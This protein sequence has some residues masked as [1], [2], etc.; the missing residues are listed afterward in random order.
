[1]TDAKERWEYYGENDPYFAVS[2]F[3]KF[4][5]ANLN[6]AGRNE[7]FSSGTVHVQRIRTEIQEHFESDF[8]PKSAIDFGCGVGR[9]VIPLAGWAEEVMGVDISEKMLAEA[10]RNCEARAIDNVKFVQTDAFMAAEGLQFDLIHSVIV[11]QHIDPA[12]GMNIVKRLVGSLVDGGIGVLHF[13]YAGD[14]EEIGSFNFRIYRDYPFIH[15][16]RNLVLGG[17]GEPLIPMYQY[18]LNKVFKL[19]HEMDCHRCFVRFTHHGT[20]GAMIFF[21]KRAEPLF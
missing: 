20:Y 16:L 14:A 2:T 21:Q 6:E 10:R 18:D 8:H 4:K 13:T 12:I 7:F 3:D 1:M 15:K 17:A 19:L 9:M 11:F 5:A